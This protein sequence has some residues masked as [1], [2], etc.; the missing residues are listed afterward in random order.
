MTTTQKSVVLDALTN[1]FARM[2]T[3]DGVIKESE[4]KE[5]KRLCENE[6]N[7]IFENTETTPSDFYADVVALGEQLTGLSTE[8]LEIEDMKL[9]DKIRAAKNAAHDVGMNLLLAAVTAL[10]SC[11]DEIS[12]EE[13]YIILFIK[14]IVDEA[15]IA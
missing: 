15:V 13:A 10:A 6:L 1:S 12:E 5:L 7:L 9:A 11:D 3:A 8:A 2:V 14:E 4:L